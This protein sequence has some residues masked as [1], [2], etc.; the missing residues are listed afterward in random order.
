[1]RLENHSKSNNYIKFFSKIHIKLYNIITSLILRQIFNQNPL[2]THKK[3]TQ[4]RT[5]QDIRVV[6]IVFPVGP[7]LA[8]STDVP[9]VQF[10]VLCNHAFDVK[11]LKCR[12]LIALCQI[13]TQ[14]FQKTF[15]KSPN[16]NSQRY[17]SE[18][19]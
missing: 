11:A 5:H 6:K 14:N 7:D 1:M 19:A 18:L 16:F 8:L 17:L 12:D 4:K 10:D 13:Q 9:N 2:K 15:Q 3:I